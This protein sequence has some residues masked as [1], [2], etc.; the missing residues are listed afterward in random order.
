M[1]LVNGKKVEIEVFPNKESKIKDFIIGDNNV[2]DFYYEDD[3][4]FVHLAFVKWDIDNNTITSENTLR[5]MYMPYSRM[6]RKMASNDVHSLPYA[7]KLINNLKFDKVIVLEPHSQESIRLLKNATAKYPVLEWVDR[8]VEETNFDK[9][10]DCIVFPDYG[11]IDRYKAERITK[12]FNYVFFKKKRDEA[13]GWITDMELE[14]VLPNGCKRAIIIDDLCSF[15]GTFF[16]AGIIL[17]GLGVEDVTLVV[18]HLENSVFQGK[19]LEKGVS[20]I[21]RIYTSNSVIRDKICDFIERINVLPI[22]FE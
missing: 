15:G 19:L 8:I 7:C 14:E 6:D 4:D 1:I 16:K 5:V 11:A 12:E 10:T 2:V 22:N 20:P 18:T 3:K 13:T 17:R 21:N 9:K